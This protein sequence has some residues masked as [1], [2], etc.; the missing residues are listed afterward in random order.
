M[1][2]QKNTSIWTYTYKKQLRRIIVFL[3]VCMIAFVGQFVAGARVAYAED[4]QINTPPVHKKTISPN[5]D[6]TYDLTLTVK[7][8]TSAASEEQKA[9][10]LVVFDNSSSMTAQTGGGEMRLDAAKRVVNQLSSTILGINRNAQKDVVEMALL[11]FNEKPN[12][13]CG[14]TT[15]LNEFQRATNNMGFHTGTNWESALERAKVLAD[16]KAANGNPTYVIFV[17]D[18]LP[19]QDRNGWAGSYQ[20][21]YEH[22]LDEARA[23]G[24]AGYHFYSVYMYGGHAYLRQLTNYAYTGN[25]LGNPGGTYYYEANNTA[26]MEQAFKEIASVITKSITYKNVT[27]NDGLDTVNMDFAGNGTPQYV[28]KKIA[29]DGT[30]LAS[31]DSTTGQTVGTWDFVK[32]TFNTA[33]KTVSWSPERDSSKVLENGVTYSI[34]IKTQP[35]QA[36]YDAMA[37]GTSLH[38]GDN[39][40]DGTNDSK[41]LYSNDNDK[42]KI[43]F[44]TILTSKSSNGTVTT[45]VSNPTESPYN[46]PVFAPVTS[47]LT[48][49]KQWAGDDHDQSNASRP[50][51]LRGV[52]TRDAGTAN[53]KKYDVTLTKS[54]PNTY[55]T[56]LTNVPAGP[57]GHTYEFKEESLPSYY[58]A[59]AVTASAQGSS[60]ANGSVVTLKGSTAQTG[61]FELTNTYKAKGEVTLSASKVLK[62]RNLEDGQFKFELKGQDDAVHQ[63]KTNDANG[64][65]TFDKI[66]YKTPGT[67]RY[68]ITESQG[69]GTG[70]KNDTH[71]ENVVVEVTD[72]G[73]GT[74]T[75]TPKY[76]ADGAVFTNQ[77][78]AVPLGVLKKSSDGVTALSGARFTLYE[79][80]GNGSYG[81]EDRPATVYSDDALTSVISNGTVTTDNQGKALFYGLVA[82]K[83]YW[84]RET[85]A[86]AGYNLD[87]QAHKIIVNADG[88]ISTVNTD[89]SEVSLPKKDNVATITISDEPIPGLPTTAGAGIVGIVSAGVALTAVGGVAFAKNTRRKK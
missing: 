16:Q 66:E 51:V 68:T 26:Q 76:D 54:G 35:T 2:S 72:N 49:T 10:V 56:T 89:G 59:S 64:T 31:Y 43:S 88:D 53:E 82:G 84:L 21:G 86:P 67:Y 79:D 81:P 27:I 37:D 69:G 1:S 55:T 13:E 17:T 83:T 3:T 34:T 57:T 14:W 30:V 48:I 61:S 46:K 73:D 5:T 44:R 32:P 65:V 7:G 78:V 8:E 63:E 18:G 36:A 28:L 6:G 20:I 87:T 38:D 19:S 41:G 47:Q 74:L 58:E 52:V 25:P 45:K 42:A 62:G 40:G 23:I 85:Q 29:S 12:L 15:D 39:D 60:S 75:A 33:N 70:Y 22:A 9:N 71:T 4:P 24:S 80:D 11:S 50:S 77:Y